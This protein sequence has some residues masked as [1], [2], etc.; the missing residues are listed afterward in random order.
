MK[1]FAGIDD[2]RSL[3]SF[4]SSPPLLSGKRQGSVIKPVPALPLIKT[5][6]W[7]RDPM[8]RRA[9]LIRSVRSSSAIESADPGEKE[10][11]V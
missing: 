8:M 10:F 6:R 5:N 11:C 4:A 7:L 9:L 3:A 1:G 2:G